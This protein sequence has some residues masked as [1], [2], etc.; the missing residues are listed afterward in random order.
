MS[1]MYLRLESAHT[2]LLY[3][4]KI[5]KTAK[6]RIDDNQTRCNRFVIINS[7]KISRFTRRLVVTVNEPGI[8]I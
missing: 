2:L 3:D 7:I 6:L 8:Q 5:S 4:E 1:R